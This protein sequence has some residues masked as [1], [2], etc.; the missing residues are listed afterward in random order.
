MCVEC[1]KYGKMRPAKIVHHILPVKTHPELAWEDRNLESLCIACHA[2]MHP[3]KGRK[4][5]YAR[6]KM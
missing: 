6:Y 4:G 2:K 1:R 3:E 5:I